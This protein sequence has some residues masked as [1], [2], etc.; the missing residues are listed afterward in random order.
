MIK[1]LFFP[2]ISLF[3]LLFPLVSFGL[4]LLFPTPPPLTSNANLYILTLNVITVLFQVFW[5]IAVAF[6]VVMFVLAGFKF[7]TAQGDPSKVHEATRAVV[8][9]IVG[10][11][12]V[13]LS[14][15]MVVIVRR[16]LGL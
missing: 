9:G 14:F 2:S 5:M 16:T 4:T 12:V 7:F 1:K 3:L 13:I 10:T 11:A 8:Y 6:V 15:S